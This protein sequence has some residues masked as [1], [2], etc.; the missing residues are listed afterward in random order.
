MWT[1]KL[2]NNIDLILFLSGIL[3]IAFG[4][5]VL[6]HLLISYQDLVYGGQ[7]HMI[8]IDSYAWWLTYKIPEVLSLILFVSAII[9]AFI[10]S[11]IKQSKKRKT[12]GD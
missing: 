4:G 3:V 5:T 6:E 12:N 9:I 7:S 11:I 10:K 8:L 2:L 1:R